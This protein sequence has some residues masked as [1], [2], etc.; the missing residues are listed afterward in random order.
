LGSLPSDLVFESIE[1]LPIY[2]AVDNPKT[3][4]IAKHGQ[5]IMY[6]VDLG[7]GN[8]R[9]VNRNF[10]DV[11]IGFVC[12][13]KKLHIEA[14]SIRAL[15]PKQ[16]HSRFACEHLKATL[17]IRYCGQQDKVDALIKDP[18]EEPSVDRCRYLCVSRGESA[19][20]DRDIRAS[21]DGGF[22]SFEFLDRGC[23][24]GVREENSSTS[25][26]EDS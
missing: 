2:P 11:Q 26:V 21:S 7:A 16:E 23:S 5:R 24:I 3:E 17:C 6:Q 12:H 15:P 14:K 10:L 9:P 25:A 4:D 20:A 8:V 1:T 18:A 13:V 22:Q 19:R